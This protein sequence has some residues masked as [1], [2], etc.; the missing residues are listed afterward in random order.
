ML[1]T[2]DLLNAAKSAAIAH[3]LPKELVCAVVE[4]ESGWETFSIRY[5]DG[6]RQRYVA[7]AHHEITEEVARSI[8]WG[9]MQIMGE[10]AR[11]L[12]FTDHLASLCVPVNG[13]E[14]GC[15]QLNKELQRAHGDVHQALLYWNGG[16]NPNYAN[17]VEARMPKYQS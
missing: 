6:F 4:Q 5:E 1:P 15:R 2:Q 17:E 10:N 9:L 14:Y 16:S 3:Q 8:S 12:G 13:L 11:E 7:P